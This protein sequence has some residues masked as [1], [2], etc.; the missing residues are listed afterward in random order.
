LT[1]L[2]TKFRAGET[3]NRRYPGKAPAEEALKRVA[4]SVAVALGQVGKYRCL[5][6]KVVKWVVVVSPWYVVFLHCL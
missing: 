2:R 6:L 5:V 4:V 3:A 1:I